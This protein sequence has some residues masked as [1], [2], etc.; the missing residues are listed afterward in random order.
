MKENTKQFL[1]SQLEEKKEELIK[2]V[3]DLIKIPSENPT[4]NVEEITKFISEYLNEGNISHD[5]IRSKEEYPNIVAQLGNDEGKTI[6]LNGH[7][8]VVPVGDLN[9]WDFDPFSGEITDTRILGRGTSDMKAGLAGIMFATRLLKEN[10]AKLKG[11]IVL[12]IVPDEETGGSMGTKWLMEN[13]YDFDAD[14]CLVA[15]PTS[16]S[17]VEVGQKGSL[18]IKIKSYGISAHGSIGNYVGE[19]AITKLMKILAEVEKLTEIK[20]VYSDKQLKVLKDSKTIAK[21]ALKAEGVENVID[22]VAV[23]IGTISGGIKTNMVPDYCESAIDVRMPIGVKASDIEEKFKNIVKGLGLDNI[24]Y[25]FNWNSEANYTDV[26]KDIVVSAVENAEKIWDK[27]VLPAYQWASSDARY[28]RYKNIPTIQYG[29]ANT[30]GIHS[31]NETVDIEDVVNS[32]KVYLG[33][34]TDL[35]EIE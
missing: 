27:E 34:L 23:N 15:E 10:N 26:D 8:D 35:L 19:N 33:I 13:G 1:W 2:L 17:N 3:S 20:G 32:T 25:E 30:E 7:A 29:P 31:Y 11:K 14:A 12:H 22:H 9:K 28:Y 4:G 16:Y 24:E 18:W 6:I 21:G 5:I